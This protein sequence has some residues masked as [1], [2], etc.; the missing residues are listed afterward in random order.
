M[1]RVAASKVGRAL[2]LRAAATSP[3]LTGLDLTQTRSYSAASAA[4]EEAAI[5][6]PMRLYG[7]SGRYATALYTAGVR[8]NALDAIATDMDMVVA[9]MKESP[10]V[11]MY[12]MD[13]TIPKGQKAST[14]TA[15]LKELKV[16]PQ[17]LNFMGA[18]AEN[19]RLDEIYKVAE[20]FKQLVRA[21]NGQVKAT[22]TTAMTL[23]PAQ[24]DQVKKAVGSMLEPGQS[25]E[26]ELNVDPSILGGLVVAIGDKRVDMSVATRVKRMHSAIKTAFS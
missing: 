9:N 17:T 19:G 15:A 25:L 1:L 13:P 2:S 3:A 14:L 5:V 23:K 7:T 6:P 20:D 26:V 10:D 11:A 4:A 24:V 18:M 16:K 12:L 8:E 22:V 21:A